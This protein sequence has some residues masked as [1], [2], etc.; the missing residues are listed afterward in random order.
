MW[1][2][3]YRETHT[4]L[5]SSKILLSVSKG[6]GFSQSHSLFNCMSELLYEKPRLSMCKSRITSLLCLKPSINYHYIGNK[7]KFLNA[8]PKSPPL[9]LCL[10]LPLGHDAP[11][12]FIFFQFRT[13]QTLP[14]SHRGCSAPTLLDSFFGKAW[15][16]HLNHMLFPLIAFRA[17][18]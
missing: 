16:L 13:C 11:T 10:L 17:P 18:S 8:A 2:T 14:A 4:D 9:S 15:P 7:S 6:E 12:T 1:P 5:W 3:N